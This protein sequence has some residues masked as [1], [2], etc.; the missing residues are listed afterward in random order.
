MFDRFIRA[1]LLNNLGFHKEID[2]R[3]VLIKIMIKNVINALQLRMDNTEE[4][5]IM[6]QDSSRFSLWATLLA[7]SLKKNRKTEPRH[8]CGFSRSLTYS[9]RTKIK[10]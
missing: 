6:Y 4:I 2:F 5:N 10:N 3:V 9:E 1:S 8:L 7:K